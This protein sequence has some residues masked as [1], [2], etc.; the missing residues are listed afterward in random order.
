[1]NFAGLVSYR[2]GFE[3]TPEA[4]NSSLAKP[5]SRSHSQGTQSR[6]R[7]APPRSTAA[8]K[9]EVS[10]W[11]WQPDRAESGNKR[12]V[13]TYKGGDRLERPPQEREP[14]ITGELTPRTKTPRYPMGSEI[15][16]GSSD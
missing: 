12:W 10:Q 1:M 16:L 11:G 4:Y 7:T 14:M 8:A 3:E 15:L 5:P 2:S 13:D 9:L 6:P